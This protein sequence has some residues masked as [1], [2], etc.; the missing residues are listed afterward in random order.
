MFVGHY[1]AGFAA[2]A[3]FPRTPLWAVIGAAQL[4]DVG[5][6][7]L[8]IFGVEK[9]RVDPA[10]PG[11]PFDLYH[12]PW[13]HSLPAALVWSALA[14][15]AA[16]L[17]KLPLH[18]CGVIAAVVFSHWILDFLVH[19]PDLALWP[20]GTKVGLG[21]WNAPTAEMAFEMGLL[22]LGG[23]AWVARR[24]D[25]RQTSWP[26]VLYLGLLAVLAIMFALPA[27]PPSDPVY[28]GV[29]GLVLFA[30]VTA[31]AWPVDRSWRP[32]SAS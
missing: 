25:F 9:F 17:A 3:A 27:P 7:T 31:L 12:M 10:L 14:A 1:A 8:I 15:G 6:S 18:I 11:N 21:F 22:M 30:F 32:A 5:F 19:R 13:T 20:G 4:L 28:T 29:F 24:E 23:A 2:K 26:A 16:R